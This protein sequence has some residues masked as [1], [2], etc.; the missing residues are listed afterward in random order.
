[1]TT[2]A[3]RTPRRKAPEPAGIFTEITGKFRGVKNFARE[4]LKWRGFLGFRVENI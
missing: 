2:E 1:M 3:Q 4:I